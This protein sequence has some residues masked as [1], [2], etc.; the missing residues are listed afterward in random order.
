MIS[1]HAV[2]PQ[3]SMTPFK[4][5]GVLLTNQPTNQPAKELTFGGDL[6]E[7]AIRRPSVYLAIPTFIASLGS[8]TDPINYN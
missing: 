8:V 5:D 3:T 7:S 6:R 4:T 1:L 2:I